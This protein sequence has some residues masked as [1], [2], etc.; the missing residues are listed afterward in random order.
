M[1]LPQSNEG[2]KFTYA[3]YL[4]WPDEERWELIDGVAYDM[5]PAPSTEH[6]EIAGELY[7]QFKRYLGGKSCKVYFAPFDVVLPHSYETEDSSTTV[8]QPDLSVI[9]D[10]SKITKN[11]CIGAPDLIVEILSPSTISKDLN[12]KYLLYEKNGVREYWVVFPERKRI[13]IFKL[14]PAGKYLKPEIYSLPDEIKVGIFD[15]LSIKTSDIFKNDEP[16]KA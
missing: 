5:T 15:D 11:G 3:D 16:E 9:C 12:E 8:V 2:P 6:Q 1:T 4:K 7:E 10:R 13:D 14:S